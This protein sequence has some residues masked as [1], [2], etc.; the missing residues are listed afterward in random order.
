MAF[1]QKVN[2]SAD[3]GGDFSIDGSVI[4]PIQATGSILINSYLSLTGHSLTIGTLVINLNPIVQDNNDDTAISLA[5]YINAN[6]TEVTASS[7]NPVVVTAITGG[8][9]GNALPLSYDGSAEITLSG[10]HLT[11]G[12]DPT[13]TVVIGKT[14]VQTQFLDSSPVVDLTFRSNSPA[15]AAVGT[16][17]V[18]NA[19]LLAPQT[20]TGTITVSDYTQLHGVAILISGGEQ[21]VEGHDWFASVDNNTTAASIGAINNGTTLHFTG[22]VANV[23]SASANGSGSSG[24]ESWYTRVCATGTFTIVDYTALAGATITLFNPLFNPDPPTVVTEGVDWHSVTSNL[25]AATNLFNFLSNNVGLDLAFQQ[26]GTV[27]SI[28]CLDFG[29]VG[30][31]VTIDSSDHTN[32]PPSGTNLTG[33]SDS[34]APS[35]ITLSGSGLDGGTDYGTLNIG[36]GTWQAGTTTDGLN[37]GVDP[38]SN[39]NTATNL[40]IALPL[41]AGF[42]DQASV[43]VVGNVVTMTARVAG[44][45]GNSIGIFPI[46]PGMTAAST[47]L[48]G[49]DP[50]LIPRLAIGTAD[51]LL[52][53]QSA[54]AATGTF[55]VTT[56]N[57]TTGIVITVG[58]TTL[59]E[60]TDWSA[61]QLQ[62]WTT[63][64]ELTAAINTIPGV[65]ATIVSSYFV[66]PVI[67]VT[68]TTPGIAGNNIVTTSS[69]P[70]AI[71]ASGTTLT[72]GSD[73]VSSISVLNA[74]ATKLT[75]NMPFIAANGSTSLP[76][77]SFINN[78]AVGFFLLFDGSAVD[79][80]AS[81]NFHVLEVIDASTL[82]VDSTI[83][84]TTGDTIVQSGYIQASSTI[85]TI[86]GRNIITLSVASGLG[87][88][89]PIVGMS[90][91]VLDVS[92]VR[93]SPG[94]STVPSLIFDTHSYGAI[95]LGLYFNT[96]DGAIT[97]SDFSNFTID[98]NL[99]EQALQFGTGGSGASLYYDGTNFNILN[100]S[101][102][103][104]SIPQAGGILTVSSGLDFG[105]ATDNS[106]WLGEDTSSGMFL[107]YS[108]VATAIQI[109]YNN[110]ANTALSIDKTTGDTSVQTH[111]IHD[112]VDPTSAQDAATKNYV[113]SSGGAVASA[114]LAG[115]TSSIN[116]VTQF[117]PTAAGLYRVSVYQVVTLADGGGSATMNA[118]ITWKD[119]SGNAQTLTTSNISMLTLGAHNNDTILV[120]AAASQQIKVTAHLSSTFANPTFSIYAGIEKIA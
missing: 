82:R 72:G 94:T 6:S 69:N 98:P 15:V 12:I 31:N 53:S 22:A 118:T 76:A 21:F 14:S 61:D 60:G 23:A 100:G 105:I 39:N 95:P 77:Y 52:S 28:V 20:A 81:V 114:L 18:D 49:T 99:H 19:A 51:M 47:F 9:A 40:G 64:L 93:L 85:A 74:G 84:L 90:G 70:S 113:D 3:F 107:T 103:G 46:T 35:G 68:A 11:G 117:T 7:A 101:S 43:S 36:N 108:S 75:A 89:G 55:T 41:N 86:V 106:L 115:Q 59:T 109:D 79:T 120:Q 56:F 92:K 80:T 104:L 87:F 37:F 102:V 58:T 78:P 62:P 44:S 5:S 71:L 65:T 26:F 33:G 67:K 24:N 83:G 57:N 1:Y 88:S 110:G 13:H 45:G 2:G 4:P 54:T 29:S 38:N 111:Q 91:D 112:V 25:Q 63:A 32:L 48:G 17:V 66:E 10:S 73:V 34:P 119:D 97:V 96:P 50:A 27:I 8:V 116:P 30:N 42:N 16:I